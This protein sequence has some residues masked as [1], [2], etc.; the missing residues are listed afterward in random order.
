MP[1]TNKQFQ[2]EEVDLSH[3]VYQNGDIGSLTTLSVTPVI[4]GDSVESIVSG[5][6]KLSPLRRNLTLDNKLD[7]Y[8]FYVPHRH[9]YPDNIFEEFLRRGPST[10]TELNILAKKTESGF[11]LS[12]AN[13][14]IDTKNF[15]ALA[16][17]YADE[18]IAVGLPNWRCSPYELIYNNYFKRPDTP[19]RSL[20]SDSDTQFGSGF[21]ACKLKNLWSASLPN[22][23]PNSGNVVSSD[24]EFMITDV[25]KQAAAFNEQQELDFFSHRY[26][27]VVNGFGGNT[28]ADVDNRPTIIATHSQYASGYDI[29]GTTEQSLG[30]F[31]GRVTQSFK[32]KI[33]RFFCNEHGSIWIMCLARFDPVVSA[34]NNYLDL[35]A[36]PNYDVFAGN[37]NV[38][39]NAGTFDLDRDRIFNHL[40]S[41]AGYSTVPHS[42]WYRY[43]CNYVSPDYVALNG[44]PFLSDITEGE[45]I[46]CNSQEYRD[47]FQTNQLKQWNIQ[48]RNNLTIFRTMPS[49]HSTI[50]QLG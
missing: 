40:S 26:R 5:S 7:F 8:A 28:T 32:F 25:V 12:P 16:I 15:R 1:I 41:S 22:S 23:T 48:A 9:C 31:S 42:Q 27:D 39:A 13:R 35:N 47:I 46:Y 24:T 18:Q 50:T 10:P 20:D 14:L 29:D 45:L 21:P 33:P 11:D 17:S 38:I 19:D 37:A 4:A 43:Q 6:F 30:Q 34:E 49:A 36:N 3:L 2:R 44:Y